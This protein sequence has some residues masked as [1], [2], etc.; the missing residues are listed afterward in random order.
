M[1]KLRSLQRGTGGGLSSLFTASSLKKTTTIKSNKLSMISVNA[2]Y[3]ARIFVF[4]NNV[5]RHNC[6]VK[7][8]RIRHG[9]LTSVNDRVISSFHEGFIFTKFHENKT[10]AKFSEFTVRSVAHNPQTARAYELFIITRK[11]NNHI[12]LT[13]P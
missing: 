12:L 4:A 9:L 6:Y 3:F 11:F 8:S 7:N 2:E 5:K 13:N 10:I 1:H